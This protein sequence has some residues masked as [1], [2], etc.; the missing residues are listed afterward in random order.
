MLSSMLD[1]L[2]KRTQHLVQQMV[3]CILNEILKSFKQAFTDWIPSNESKPSTVTM[4]TKNK[5]KFK[6]ILPDLLW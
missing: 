2:F 1:D 6:K 4:G 3:E 5:R